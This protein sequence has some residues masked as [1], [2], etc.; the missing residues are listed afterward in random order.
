V[1]ALLAD[2][3]RAGVFV[4]ALD[5]PLVRGETSRLLSA[6]RARGVS[7]IGLLWNRARERPAPLS[8]PDDAPQFVSTAI[9]PPPV[10]VAAL[11][12]WRHSWTS[13]TAT[14]G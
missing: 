12:R 5:E 13:L 3:T 6:V 10:G 2:P 14:D 9:T 4:V 11:R 8:M 7:V 1:Q